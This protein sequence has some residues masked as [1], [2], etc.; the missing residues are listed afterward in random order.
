MAIR[1]GWTKWTEKDWTGC[2]FSYYLDLTGMVS[3]PHDHEAVIVKYSGQDKYGIR[4]T[5]YEARVMAGPAG[6]TEYLRV[7]DIKSARDA[8]L[9]V[10]AAV[11]R[12]AHD[13]AIHIYEEYRELVPSLEAAKAT[14]GEIARREGYDY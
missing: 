1:K 13:G 8:R 3:H 14:A 9:L 2:Q 4:G 10:E 6:E 5:Y 12:A 7:P 11:A